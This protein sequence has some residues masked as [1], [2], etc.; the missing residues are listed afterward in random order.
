MTVEVLVKVGEMG[1]P[2]EG[3]RV[4]ARLT[5]ASV[6]PRAGVGA[7][8]VS[9]HGR[10]GEG[11]ARARRRAACREAVMMTEL[12]GNPSV[13][14]G[15]HS[16]LVPYAA[17]RRSF[18]SSQ[19]PPTAVARENRPCAL[20]SVPGFMGF[21]APVSVIYGSSIAR[22]TLYDKCSAVPLTIARLR[23]THL[24]KSQT[25]ISNRIRPPREHGLAICLVRHG[26]T[27]LFLRSACSLVATYVPP[28]PVQ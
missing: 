28:T 24:A 10:K 1:G 5:R 20:R 18:T 2:R 8:S 19:P 17:Q 6:L 7:G 26:Y 12:S 21:I 15:V 23:S 22:R 4:A 16:P 3:R 13:A 9:C 11:R 27:S 14:V 25:F